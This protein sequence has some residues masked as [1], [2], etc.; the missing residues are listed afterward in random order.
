MTQ[1]IKGNFKLNFFKETVKCIIPIQRQTFN[2]QNFISK[3]IIKIFYPRDNKFLS[4][5][6]DCKLERQRL[7]YYYQGKIPK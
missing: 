6:S 3:K 4:L 2:Y 1:L 7:K 5:N